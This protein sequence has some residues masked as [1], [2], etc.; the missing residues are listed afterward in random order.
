M[1]KQPTVKKR[2]CDD[3][4]QK[5]KKENVMDRILTNVEKQTELMGPMFDFSINR[6]GEQ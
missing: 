1:S 6:G 5:K 4:T 2:R 3:T